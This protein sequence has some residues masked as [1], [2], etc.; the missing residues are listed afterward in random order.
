MHLFR[1]KLILIFLSLFLF[2]PMIPLSVQASEAGSLKA[3]SE[4]DDTAIVRV[5]DYIPE[6]RQSLVYSTPNNV[7]GKQIYDFTDAYLRY[8]T[9]KKLAAACRELATLDLG[10]LILD[11]YRPIDFQ[12]DLQELCPGESF[13][14]QPENR[15]LLHCRGN[16]VDVTLVDLKTGAK[17]PSPT[18]YEFSGK[19]A[20]RDF[21]DCPADGALYAILLENIMKKH[22]FEPC[23]D[24]WWHFTDTEE[25]SVE[26]TFHPSP[27]GTWVANCKS[28]IEL[29][30]A[31]YSTTVLGYIRAGESMEL[32]GWNDKYARVSYK[33]KRGYVM[34]CY[35]KPQYTGYFETNLSIVSPTAS[36][37]YEQMMNDLQE[38][39]AAH[40]DM[41]ALDTIGF[42]ELER[43]IPV[44]R[45]GNENA[46]YHVL[47]Q[48]AMH[49]REHMTA[50]LLTA[51]ADYWSDHNL[52]SY[53][54][55]CFH[56]IPMS[57][58]DGV[59]ISQEETLSDDLLKIYK[60]D[61]RK[62]YTNDSRKN[63]ARFWKA[64][65]LGEDI[66]R[67][68]PDG[69]MGTQ[70]RS[71]PSYRNYP[72]KTPFS[73]SEARALRDYTLKYDF[74]ATVS[75]HATGSL[76]FYEYGKKREVNRRSR[77]LAKAV[78]KVSGYTLMSNSTTGGAGYKDWAIQTLEIPS[79]TLEVGCYEAPLE[80]REIYSLF[81]RNY[82]VLPAIAEWLQE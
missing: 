11:A 17:K 51:M 53:G 73:T 16:T 3:V 35:I 72:G 69:F 19:Q 45:I 79:L 34:S 36:Y 4:P 20:D 55:V 33:G 30:S 66:N 60:S 81:E 62:G 26:K 49:G 46:E 52:L 32:L 42:S 22:G 40:P 18:E 7:T 6:I 10:I 54:D 59:T 37:S 41:V 47:L 38:M 23:S 74:D 14:S 77:S 56:I 57:N 75:Y 76:I 80:E 48:G 82:K 9:V 24:Q 39:E 1:C 67:N 50:W 44:I 61:I 31:P 12:E 28:R 27:Y 64:N 65:A 8:G 71:A 29:L 63:Y 78:R 68:F 2:I 13:A 21:R 58:P 5:L 25:Y 15:D 70:D 43:Q